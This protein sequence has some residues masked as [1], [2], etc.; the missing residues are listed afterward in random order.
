MNSVARS[1]PVA[2]RRLAT[3]ELSH[4]I[5]REFAGRIAGEISSHR[6]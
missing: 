5:G 1:V 4:T 6:V 3:G 2:L